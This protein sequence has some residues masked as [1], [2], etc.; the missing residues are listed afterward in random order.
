[1]T[2]KYPQFPPLTLR[3][4]ERFLS[5][6]PRQEYSPLLILRQENRSLVKRKMKIK[7]RAG[8]QVPILRKIELP[9]RHEELEML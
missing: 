6:V 7:N 8:D 5:L 2:G 4:G 1:M 3:L 9:Y